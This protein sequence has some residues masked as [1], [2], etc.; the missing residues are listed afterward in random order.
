MHNKFNILTKEFEL[1]KKKIN[2][3]PPISQISSKDFSKYHSLISRKEILESQI[4]KLLQYKDDIVKNYST[5]NEKWLYDDNMNCRTY[6]KLE[7][8]AA[9][10]RDKSLYKLGFADSKPLH[11][12]LQ[13]LKQFIS[14]NISQPASEKLNSIKNKCKSFIN[15]TPIPKFDNFI[16]NTLPSKFTDV[17]ISGTKKCILGYRSISN[18]LNQSTKTFSRNIASTPI[19]QVLSYINTQAKKEADL[20]SNSFLSRIKVDV[21]TP[22]YS[23]YNSQNF[24]KS[25]NF[26]SS[27]NSKSCHN[28]EE[29]YD[30][31]L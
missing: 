2:Q 15:K 9:Y 20:Q 31:A 18:C 11:P 17:A 13:N 3:C 8:K 16:Q 10:V 26:N 30:L 19:I 29:Y 22:N 7:K 21:T 14:T 24:S 28:S 25:N 1:L 23:Y 12:V 27:H 4:N 6:C 5:H